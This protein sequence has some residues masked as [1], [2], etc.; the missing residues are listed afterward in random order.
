MVVQVV[1]NSGLTVFHNFNFRMDSKKKE[2]YSVSEKG[3]K[4]GF[5]ILSLSFPSI[6]SVFSLVKFIDL[7]NTFYCK[8]T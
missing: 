3:N 6:C 4:S 7:C 8:F 2:T 5:R 1:D